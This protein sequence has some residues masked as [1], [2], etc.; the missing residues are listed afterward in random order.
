MD[1]PTD[2]AGDAGSVNSIDITYE[3]AKPYLIDESAVRPVLVSFWASWDEP[4][5]LMLPILERLAVEYDGAFLLAKVNVEQLQQLAEQFGVQSLPTIMVMNQGQPV[6]GLQGPQTEQAITELLNKC[7]PAPWLAVVEQGLANIEA[8]NFAEGIAQL[9]SAHTDSNQDIQVTFALIGGL[10]KAR[11]LEDASALLAGVKMVDQG[12]EYHHL[13]AQL[14][15]AQNAAKAPEIEELEAKY[16]ASPND[17]DV[18][19][20]LAAQYSQHHHYKE[21]LELLWT[22]LNKDLN[23]KEGEIKRIYMDVLSVV[24]K[25]DPLAITYLQKLY[26]KLY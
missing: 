14:E 8:E 5:Q 18:V 12:Q 11:R 16:Q 22:V 20:A 17:L 1:L 2:I 19:Q 26:A 9:R 15:L 6:D 13:T 25:G 24:G 7:L 4:S 21:A 23:A 3:N 10:I